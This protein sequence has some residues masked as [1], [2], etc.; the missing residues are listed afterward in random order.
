MC[1][2]VIEQVQ[3]RKLTTFSLNY[4]NKIFAETEAQVYKTSSFKYIKNISF[5]FIII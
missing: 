3:N 5:S 1:F 4:L 2:S